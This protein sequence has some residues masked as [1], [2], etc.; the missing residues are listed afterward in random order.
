MSYLYISICSAPV[1]WGFPSATSLARKVRNIQFISVC[2]EYLITLCQLFPWDLIPFAKRDFD[3]TEINYFSKIFPSSGCLHQS[4]LIKL[5]HFCCTWAPACYQ[6]LHAILVNI[7]QLLT[8]VGQ[9]YWDTPATAY[10]TC[11]PCWPNL[12]RETIKCEMWMSCDQ[13]VLTFKCTLQKL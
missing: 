10:P 11:N 3:K 2:T 5:T 8:L 7:Q 4:G 9:I 6:E 13:V 1:M 12:L